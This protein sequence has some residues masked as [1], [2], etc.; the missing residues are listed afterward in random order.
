[1]AE[2]DGTLARIVDPHVFATAILAVIVAGDE[3]E[4]ELAVGEE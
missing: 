4:T 1:M 2:R 3:L